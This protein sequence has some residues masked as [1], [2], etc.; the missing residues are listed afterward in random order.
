MCLG[1]GGVEVDVHVDVVTVGAAAVGDVGVFQGEG[2][3][4]GVDEPGVA[5][6]E[7]DEILVGSVHVVAFAWV[8]GEFRPDCVVTAGAFFFDPEVAEFV[9]IVDGGD[10]ADGHEDGEC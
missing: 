3:G 10:A 8:F 9:T 6:P 1:W 5:T 2:F 7:S 4:G